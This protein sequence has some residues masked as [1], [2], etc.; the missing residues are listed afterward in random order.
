MLRMIGFSKVA[1]TSEVID[2]TK[3]SSVVNAFS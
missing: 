3:L 2:F 1:S